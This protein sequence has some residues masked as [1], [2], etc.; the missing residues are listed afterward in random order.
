MW[1]P[2][3]HRPAR[4]LVV[5]GNTYLG[6]SAVRTDIGGGASLPTTSYSVDDVPN[7]QFL[8]AEPKVPITPME[9]RVQS[10]QVQPFAA[11]KPG[12]ARSLLV[13]SGAPSDICSAYNHLRTQ[14]VKRL[15]V[16]DWKTVAL[17]SP[18]REA[19]TTLTAINLA[20][21]IARNVGYSVLLVELN[22][23]NPSFREILGFEQRQGIVDHLLRDVPIA[24]LLLN[25]GI[26]RLDVLPAGSSVTNSS[27]LLSSPKMHLLVEELK[28]RN[29]YRVILFDLPS[30]M[31]IDDAMAFSPSVDCVLLVVEEGGTR[32]SDVRRAIDYLK[33]ARI[34]GIVLNRSDHTE[35]R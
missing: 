28:Y 29:E 21:S 4:G 24:E 17:T 10:R 32:V 15:Q 31:A 7:W 12:V 27:E 18:S 9:L 5:G 11:V 35:K 19:G 25:S 16:N 14:I 26:E 3:R 34:L 23:V 22:L 1:L 20:I 13:G 2:R 30:V 8:E 6:C 33:P